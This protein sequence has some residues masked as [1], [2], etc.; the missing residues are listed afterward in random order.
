M[1]FNSY[2]FIIFFIVV[3]VS[4][5]SMP[6]R[7][8]WLFLLVVSYFYYM[9]WDPKFALLLL[10]TTL[11][12]YLSALLM[13][14]KPAKVKKLYVAASLI[15]NLGI[16]F[17]FKYFNFFN[18]T[19][20]EVSKFAGL[21]YDVPALRILLPVGIS[22]YTFQALGYVIDVYRGTRKPE[23]NFGMFALYV[24][25][26]PVLLAGPIERST[27][28]L[29]QLYEK[30]EFDYQRITDG[31]KLIAWGAFQKLVIADRLSMYVNQ[32]YNNP[33]AHTGLPL[34]LAS[35]FF[36]IQVYCD[37][38]GYTDI[39]IGTAQVMGYK[40][41]PNFRRPYFAQTL[42][43]LW[44]RWHISLISWFRDYLYI[45]MG[46]NRVP[47]SRFYF[48][49]M[50]VF[51][52]SGLWHG[53]QWTFVIWGAMN[54][55][56]L[57]ISR[58]TQKARLFIRERLFAALMNVPAGA[59]FIASIPLAVFAV[60][61]GHEG[62]FSAP[63]ATITASACAAAAVV[64][65]AVSLNRGLYE[66]CINTLKKLMMI[67]ITVHLFVLGAVFFRAGSVRDAWYILTHFTG[68]NFG[69]LMLNFDVVRFV[70]MFL[71]TAVLLIIHYVQ[72]TRGSIR[73]LIRQKPVWLRW[74]L[75][76]F[77]CSSILLFGYRGTQQFIYFRF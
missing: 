30:M 49:M 32:V 8:R 48:N 74:A 66:R 68:T 41:I 12:V 50:V 58:M 11:V 77:L 36:I 70:M 34:L 61:S 35:Y 17:L 27:T 45:P 6:H 76:F 39:A 15:I 75:Y 33:H 67:L 4:F 26:F 28:L 55:V 51:T 21:A 47:R 20:R 29:P 60:W 56:F 37:F 42:G 43:E 10:F 5:F 14:D 31:L 64:L 57:I 22:F 69:R 65:G 46:G 71:V 1:A 73:Q 23:R 16:L 63:G 19:L 53:A 72:E 9:C 40:L 2:K 38:S 52:V 59:Y 44:R 18:D 62:F 7:Y 54:G 25:F 24:S 13:H 3:V